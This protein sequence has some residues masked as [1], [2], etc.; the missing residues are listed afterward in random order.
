MVKFSEASNSGRRHPST[1][2]LKQQANMLQSSHGQQ[3]NDFDIP[4]IPVFVP[5]TLASPNEIYK[6]YTFYGPKKEACEV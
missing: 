1:I 2:S 3:Y 4:D 5:K 6:K